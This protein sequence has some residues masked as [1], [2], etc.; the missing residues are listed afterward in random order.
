MP[1]ANLSSFFL[2]LSLVKLKYQR[3]ESWSEKAS[4]G[5]QPHDAS[6]INSTEGIQRDIH[7]AWHSHMLTVKQANPALSLGNL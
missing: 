6:L 3:T 2:H 4:K 5:L 7:G 1:C